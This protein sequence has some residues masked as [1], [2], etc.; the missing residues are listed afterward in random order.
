MA[1]PPGLAWDDRLAPY[2][3]PRKGAG[4]YFLCRQT[5]HR[6]GKAKHVAFIQGF[7]SDAKEYRNA[8]DT[9]HHNTLIRAAGFTPERNVTIDMLCTEYLQHSEQLEVEGKQD[10]ATTRF[11]HLAIGSYVRPGLAHLG[12]RSVRELDQSVLSSFIRWARK[13]RPTGGGATIGKAIGALKTM[14]RWKGFGTIAA[15]LK[16]PTREIAA[17]RREKRDLDATTIRRLIAAMPEGSIEEA[18][19]YLK[20]RTGARDVEIFRARPDEFD[21]RAATF[22]PTL[23]NKGRGRAKRHVYALT[24][25]VI[26]KL[27]PFVLAAKQGGYVFATEEGKAITREWLRPRIR[28][29]SRRAGIVSRKRN[30]RWIGRGGKGKKSYEHD[31]GAIDSIAP[32]RS[33]VATVVVERTSLKEAARNI[34][35]DD[36]DTLKRWYLKDRLTKE[37]LEERRRVAEIV[38]TALPLR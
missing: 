34:G 6:D 4:F 12:V 31:I 15:D 35:W 24:S 38:A 18:V 9:A 10:P 26:A 11:H 22:A 27:R 30:T 37:A 23:K 17:V 25:D 28:A 32:I 3:H 8:H 33:E 13:A 14:L 21:L 5:G 7:R 1:L 29:A 16:I 2:T 36:E 20:A 19:S